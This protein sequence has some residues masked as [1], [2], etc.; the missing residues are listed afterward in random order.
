MRQQKASPDPSE[1]RKWHQQGL[2]AKK[3]V[4]SVLDEEFSAP[5]Q[6]SSKR[7]H[8]QIPAH[9]ATSSELR[10]LLIKTIIGEK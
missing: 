3:N 10:L 1:D 6:P 4:G 7:R 8:C 9:F 5:V 2:P